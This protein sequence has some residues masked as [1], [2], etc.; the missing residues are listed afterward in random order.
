MVCDGLGV[1]WAKAG[2]EKSANDRVAAAAR[3]AEILW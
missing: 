3:P 1:G 2:L